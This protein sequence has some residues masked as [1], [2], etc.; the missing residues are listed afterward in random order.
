MKQRYKLFCNNYHGKYIFLI[1]WELSN[2]VFSCYK[3][4]EMLVIKVFHLFHKWINYADF[5]NIYRYIYALLSVYSCLN[6]AFESVHPG[7]KVPV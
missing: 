1:F 4:V 5:F 3:E 6:D 7:K 2:Q